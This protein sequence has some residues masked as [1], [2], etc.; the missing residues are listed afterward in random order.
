MFKISKSIV[1]RYKKECWVVGEGW[2]G[3]EI[4]GRQLFDMLD[5]GRREKG[6]SSE[7][8]LSGHKM[9]HTDLGLSCEKE[10]F[11]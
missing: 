1:E 7:N 11:I 9:E 3:W 2:R 10:V 5:V 6:G 8:V 4:R